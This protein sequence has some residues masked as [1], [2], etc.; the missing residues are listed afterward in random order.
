VCV[1][2]SRTLCGGYTGFWSCRVVLVSVSKIFI[3]AFCHLVISGVRCSS[4]LWMELVPP[5]TSVS[6]P[7]S[8]TLSWVPV[9]RALSAGNL[10]SGREDTQRSGAQ[11]CLLAEDEGPKCPCPRTSVASVAHLFSCVDWSLRDPRYKMATS[12][13]S[14]DQNPLWRPTLL[15]Q[16]RCPE[17]WVSALPPGWGWRPKGPLSK[18]L[19]CFWCPHALL[20][21]LVSER[22]VIQDLSL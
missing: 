2:V 8:P 13:E 14:Q 5:V 15:W 11:L 18:K 12:P 19:S 21:G 6:T 20:C 16:G 9:V 4:W 10:S 22:P 1:G 3:F 17:V 7:G